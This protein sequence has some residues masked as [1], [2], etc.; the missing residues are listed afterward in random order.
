M[1]EGECVEVVEDLC[2]LEGN[3]FVDT[4]ESESEIWEIVSNGGARIE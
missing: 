4:E 3:G 1:G 2:C